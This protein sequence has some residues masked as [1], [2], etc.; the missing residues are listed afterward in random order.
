MDE[1]AYLR[2][3]DT[4]Y[5][6]SRPIGQHRSDYTVVAGLLIMASAL[7]T[8]TMYCLKLRKIRQTKPQS[9]V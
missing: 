6:D 1:V 3:P 9:S 5:Y 8:C 4:I 7:I 2:G